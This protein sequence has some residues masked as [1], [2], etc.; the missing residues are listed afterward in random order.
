MGIRC[1]TTC[2]DDRFGRTSAFFELDIRYDVDDLILTVLLAARNCKITDLFLQLRRSFSCI[3]SAF[4][5]RSNLK[6]IKTSNTLGILGLTAR[7]ITLA[8]SG[9]GSP[10]S[11]ITISSMCPRDETKALRC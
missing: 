11:E 8:S 7:S 5:T 1:A 3:D 6:A 9:T 2:T 4:M 10:E